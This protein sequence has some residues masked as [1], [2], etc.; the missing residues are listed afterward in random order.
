MFNL[1]T[2]RDTIRIDPS[3]FGAPLDDAALNE[4]RDKYE[5]LVDEE[6]G[7][8]ISVIGLKVNPFG[9]IIPGD[10]GPT[11]PSPSPSSPST[12]R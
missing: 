2:L 5:G 9:R 1:I 12:P 8:V 11:T 10:G 7:Y 4:L 6:L 3:R